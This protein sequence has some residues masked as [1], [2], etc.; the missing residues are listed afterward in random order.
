MGYEKGLPRKRR[1][2]KT[3]DSSNPGI[4]QASSHG[5]VPDSAN[6][7]AGLNL[8][9]TLEQLEPHI[10]LCLI[11]KS[12]EEWRATVVPFLAI[13]LRQGQK[14]TYIVDTSTADE[15]RRY[16]IEEGIDVS[17]VENSHQLNIL[18]ET[19]VYT[20]DGSFDPDRMIDLLIKET[21]KA[22]SE[23]YSALRVTGEMTW[24]LHGYPGSEKI[25]E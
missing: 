15:V 14:C 22:V 25:M 8:L 6:K 2:S 21:E 23:G 9:Q 24:V 10:H 18:H 16:L 11:Y 3:P 7:P 1:K 13:G 12:K 20:R 4:K 19:E 5:P 17:S